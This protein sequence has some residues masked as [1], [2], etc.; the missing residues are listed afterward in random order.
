MAL[1]IAQPLF[2]PL[3]DQ[4]Y[5]LGHGF[6]SVKDCISLSHDNFQVFASLLDARYIAGSREVFNTLIERIEHKLIKPKGEAF[7]AWLAEQRKNRLSRHGDAEHAAG[8]AV[9]G[10]H[11]R[12]ARLA[13]HALGGK[14]LG[15]CPLDCYSPDDMP[16]ELL[17][18]RDKTLLREAVGLLEQTRN[19]LHKWSKRKN[20]LLHQEL[21][22][23][24][25]ADMGFTDRT[26]VLGVELFLSALHKSMNDLK[27]VS[28]AFWSS[29]VKKESARDAANR[30][31]LM[32]YDVEELA[33]LHGEA[34][35][36]RIL[37]LFAEAAEHGGKLSW[38]AIRTV[39]CHLDAVR[40]LAPFQRSFEP[41]ERILLSGNAAPVLGQMLDSGA[42]G[43]LIPE[44]G[45]VSDHVQF[46]SYHTYP[47]GRHSLMTLEGLEQLGQEDGDASP[48]AASLWKKTADK[49]ALLLAAL[50]HDIGKPHPEHEL[51]GGRIAE[52]ILQRWQL[53]RDTIDNV[54]FLI[55]EHLLLPLTA[56]RKDIGN[57][58]I[59]LECARQVHSIER[60]EMLYLLSLVDAQATGPKAWNDWNRRLLAELFD[61]VRHLLQ[62]SCLLDKSSETRIMENRDKVRSPGR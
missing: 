56:L 50:L 19:Q 55:Q 2:L 5:D 26:H 4:G 23:K 57:E 28:E 43:A 62:R 58:T 7:V 9:E 52:T 24:V 41:L 61:K 10:R 20:D 25:A 14:A 32:D 40:Q 17:S 1:D 38:Q 22:P 18:A 35:A 12:I 36:L 21:Q 47:V 30:P 13:L 8:T 33:F 29:R 59:V 3:W 31:R 15:M 45:E 39:S 27:L 60:L 48:H 53:G 11:R 54:V 16:D 42:L 34:L 6:R 37:D 46:D 51:L 49:K 44:F